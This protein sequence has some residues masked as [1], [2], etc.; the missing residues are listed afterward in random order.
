MLKF[1]ELLKITINYGG[2]DFIERF[3]GYKTECKKLVLKESLLEAC[4]QMPQEE[5]EKFSDEVVELLFDQLEN[6]CVDENEDIDS[7]FFIWEKGTFREDIW[8]WIDERHS[9]GIHWLMYEREE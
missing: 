5:Y 3:L 4:K 8:H 9:K 6:Q 7:D 2:K 1:E